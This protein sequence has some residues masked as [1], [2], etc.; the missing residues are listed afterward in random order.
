M[1]KKKPQENK[2]KKSN[3]NPRSLV[4]IHPI[5]LYPPRE[6]S[7]RA[8]VIKKE[9]KQGGQP[10]KRECRGGTGSECRGGTPRI[11][12]GSV[13]NVIT[14]NSVNSVKRMLKCI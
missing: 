6:T 4:S 3:R 5:L 12:V 9:Q 14:L 7:E 10:A 1:E 13:H 11:I 2:A 8:E